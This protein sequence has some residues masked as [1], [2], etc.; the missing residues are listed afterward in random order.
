MLQRLGTLMGATQLQQLLAAAS[1]EQGRR[2]GTSPCGAPRLLAIQRGARMSRGERLLA[3]LRG[4]SSASAARA[5]PPCDG[6]PAAAA[7]GQPACQNLW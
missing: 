5:A 3:A 2:A 4:G 6:G 7:G 1:G